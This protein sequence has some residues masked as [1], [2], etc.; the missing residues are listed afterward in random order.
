MVA[1][2][3]VAHLDPVLAQLQRAGRDHGGLVLTSSAEVPFRVPLP[4]GYRWLP[5]RHLLEADDGELRVQEGAIRRALAGVPARAVIQRPPG[6]PG[7]E[8]LV[9]GEFHRRGRVGEVEPTL[10]AE[11]SVLR[12]WLV[13]SHPDTGGRSL[14]TI[15]NIIR[16]AHAAWRE[17]NPRPTK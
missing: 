1:R 4:N 3:V 10:R 15:E 14:G 12:S 13:A 5:L 7:I 8:S 11:A 2:D 17:Q 16:S 9:L 6:R